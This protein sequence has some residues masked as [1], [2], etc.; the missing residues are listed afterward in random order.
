MIFVELFGIK[1]AYSVFNKPNNLLIA[2]TVHTINI[3]NSGPN[4]TN[5]NP[6]PGIVNGNRDLG[7]EYPQ[8]KRFP[9]QKH[10]NIFT[11]QNHIFFG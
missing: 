1:W 5:L 10:F 2:C 6:D 8:A 7:L 3:N 4:L 11:F 9:G